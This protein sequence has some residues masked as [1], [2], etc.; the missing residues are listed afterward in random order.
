MKFYFF[1]FLF[2]S[3]SLMA[4]DVRE[5]VDGIVQNKAKAST[6]CR[7]WQTSF[8]QENNCNYNGINFATSRDKA[9]CGHK[10]PKDHANI[11]RY[12]A[13]DSVATT[14]TYHC[15]LYARLPRN[16][17]YTCRDRYGHLK[18]R[19]Y[20]PKNAC[21]SNQKMP[22][23]KSV[24]EKCLPSCGGAKGVYCRANPLECKRGNPKVK[25]C[26]KVTSSERQTKK[27]VTLESY[28]FNGNCCLVLS[29]T[30]PFSGITSTRGKCGTNQVKPH[31]KT[32]EWSL[33]GKPQV[34]C[35]PSCGAAV[36]LMCRERKI[37]RKNS[38]AVD[39]LRTAELKRGRNCA[40]D[41]NPDLDVIVLDTYAKSACCLVRPHRK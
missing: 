10:L 25:H 32:I 14:K 17:R 33:R 29:K 34:S 2:V 4:H 21:K 5:G 38:K 6:A 30:A 28:Q 24:G 31:W 13:Y 36:S 22:H 23:W 26:S 27:V 40:S 3:F 8:C 41:K 9:Q 15:C 12:I 20:P 37:C 18:K 16:K 35:V 19:C 39:N 1:V 11:I 7:E